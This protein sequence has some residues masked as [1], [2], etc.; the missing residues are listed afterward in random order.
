ML[1]YAE[2]RFPLSGVVPALGTE[3]RAR[4]WSSGPPPAAGLDVQFQLDEDPAFGSPLINSTLTNQ[5]SGSE[6]S[7]T[8]APLVNETVYYWRVR[9]S[10]AGTGVWSA[11]V[12]PLLPFLV[13]TSLGEAVSYIYENVGET[14]VASQ[15]GTE[16]I[17][18]NA[19]W[20]DDV[21]PSQE[22]VDYIYE[23]VGEN[24]EAPGEGW[25]Y[26]WYG[27][28]NTDTPEPVLWFLLPDFGREGDG[29]RL[30]CYGVGEFQ[31]TFDGD[32]ELDWGG[33]T[34]WQSI[35]I[36]SW[37]SFPATVDAYGPDR[38]FDEDPV[39]IDMEHTIIEAVI[40]AGTVPPGYLVR[41]RTDGP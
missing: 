39:H 35:T 36:V 23:N 26:L 29:F 31:A 21:I 5:P 7:L 17:Y 2:P 20:G 19:G 10:A 41:I 38:L 3:L 11:W 33:I 1:P 28:V 4:A 16:Y 14:Y 18:E 25:S 34:S 40:P 37:E 30:Y 32:V 9:S 12:S 8:A 13:D 6:V 27:D 24:E 15:E 22:D